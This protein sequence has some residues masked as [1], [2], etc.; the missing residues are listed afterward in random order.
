MLR[1]WLSRM[2]LA[3]GWNDHIF[4]L[5]RKKAEKLESKD[6]VCGIVFDAI[7]LKSGLY[8]NVTKD[9]VDGVED[10]GQYGR[11]EQTAEYAMVFMVKGLARKW[12]KVLAYFFP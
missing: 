10:L 4:H 2:N 5:L 1:Y 9:Q 12:K 3:P 11:S 7:S 8:Y 6:N